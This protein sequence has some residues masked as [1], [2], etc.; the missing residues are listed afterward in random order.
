MCMFTKLLQYML[1]NGHLVD[2]LTAIKDTE[3]SG[4]ES[5]CR[6]KCD[7]GSRSMLDVKCGY[8][9]ELNPKLCLDLGGFRRMNI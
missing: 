2:F 8:R 6:V 4:L 1:I 7:R 9:N 3:L 5:S